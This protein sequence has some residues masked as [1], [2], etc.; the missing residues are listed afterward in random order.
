MKKSKK[1]TGWG[2]TYEI[3]GIKTITIVSAKTKKEAIKK[4]ESCGFIVLEPKQVRHVCVVKY[5]GPK[6]VQDMKVQNW[7]EAIRYLQEK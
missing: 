5:P 4:I 6:D 2:I 7:N 3:D 1:Y